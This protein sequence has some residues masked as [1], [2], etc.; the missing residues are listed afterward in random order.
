[1]DKATTACSPLPSLPQPLATSQ[2]DHSNT[3]KQTAVS[4]DETRHSP[5]DQPLA[6]EI[7]CHVKEGPKLLFEHLWLQGKQH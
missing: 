4:T 3:G 1:M 2:A 7:C 6:R 5:F